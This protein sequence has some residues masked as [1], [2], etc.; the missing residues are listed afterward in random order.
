MHS[1][2]ASMSAGARLLQLADRV[3][4]ALGILDVPMQAAELMRH[5]RRQTGL[6]DFGDASFEEPLEILLQDYD[7]S[8]NL[9]LFGRIAARW[10]ILRYLTNLLLLKE[11]ESQF[12]AIL[13]Q[14][15]DRPIF[16]TGLPRSGTSFLHR[17]L[18]EDPGNLVARHWETIYPCP[19]R[20]ASEA[21]F[22]NSAHIVDRQL[23]TFA[24]LAP[25]IRSLHPMTADSPQECTEITGHVFRS[26]RF[27]TT[28]DVPSYHRWLDDSAH[29]PAYEFHKRFLQHLQHRKGAGRWI[30]KCP[31]HAFVLR[32]IRQVYPDA[33][34]VFMHRDPLKVLPSVARLTE[35]LRRPFTRRVDRIQIGQQVRE[36]WAR[37]AALLVEA[38]TSA[39]GSGDRVL[40]L[41]FRHFVSDPLAAVAAVYRHFG[42]PPHEA[43]ASR[44]RGIIATRR[45]GG[46]GRNEYRLEDYGLDAK[47]ERQRFREYMT[48]FRVEHEFTAEPAPGK[49]RSSSRLATSFADLNH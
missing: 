3:A 10:D 43:V 13:K 17:L 24:R 25:E 32:Q 9:S 12:P 21:D 27:E 5:A 45:N 37:G 47:T 2:T 48:Y 33:C 14:Q 31:D 18:A 1:A 20:G 34:F 19:H 46:Y 40:N 6:T 39:A 23:S 8:A 38:N 11:E 41:Q 28:H 15:I 4:G 49:P 7:R 26:L 16:I 44:L 30:L 36:S 42:M 29:L 35:V 22:A